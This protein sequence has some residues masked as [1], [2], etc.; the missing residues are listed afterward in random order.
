MTASQDFFH[1]RRAGILLHPT[2]LPETPSN[3]D[4]G[5]QAYRFVDFLADCQITIW[6][7]LPLGPPHEDL[8]PY[9]CQS[10]H[11]ANPLLISLDKL[12]AKGWLSEDSS[13]C[14]EKAIKYELRRLSRQGWY[15]L[16]PVA[17]ELTKLLAPTPFKTGFCPLSH[18][19]I[20]ICYR[21]ARLREAHAG[22]KKYANDNDY[23]AYTD[24]IATQA[25]WLA[26]YALFRALQAEHLHQLQAECVTA[27][28]TLHD[29]ETLHQQLTTIKNRSG[30][31]AW[32]TEL[33]ERHP[34]ALQAARQRLS[35][36]IEQHYFEQFVF[37]TQWQE[38]KQYANE[39]GIYLFGDIPI[40]VALDS[41]DVWAER[42][43]FLLDEQ[44]QPTVVAGV[45]PDYF[46]ATGQRWGNPHYNWE[47][48]QRNDFQW[49]I[50]RLKSTEVLF[51]V[52]RI[53]HFRGFEACWTIPRS[54][55]T[56][57][58]GQW[59]KVPGEALFKRL[60][61]VE[62]LP[63][64]AEDL[65][66]ITDEVIALRDQFN[67]PGMKI[68]QFAFDSGPSNPYLPHNHVENSVVYTGTHDNNTTLG[69]FHELTPAVQQDVCD[70]LH[71]SPQDMPW[72]LIE[73]AFASIANLAVVPWQD[74][75]GLDG[76]HRMNMPG[77]STGNWRW[78]FDWSQI[79]PGLPE[80]MRHLAVFYGRT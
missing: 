21:Q 78:R 64:I 23:A 17:T 37:F 19:E 70:Y 68:L 15:H 43:N 14:Q 54:C 56:A 26:D 2:S 34:L 63:L 52:V 40:F 35:P 25:D 6:Q 77:T 39:R 20:A 38:L 69:W 42:Q 4:L 51:D 41:V 48:M 8:S 72:P 16:D 22:F 44:G 13:P 53:D 59:V 47:Y 74:V 28:Q 71:A 36:E 1:K 24:F 61:Q 5:Q 9:Q 10:V 75:L 49:W 65:G 29:S 18:S 32:P 80:K 66:V 33:R 62:T 11:A 3:G 67:L 45:P 31:W 58:E 50:R 55:E 79:P 46:S 7:M 60:Q 76:Q 30:W 73:A 12:V 27:L 57:M